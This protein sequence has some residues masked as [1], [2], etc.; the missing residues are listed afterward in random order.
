M[1]HANGNMFLSDMIHNDT[2]RSVFAPKPAVMTTAEAERWK[3]FNSY[4]N[5]DHNQKTRERLREEINNAT[6]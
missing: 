5:R 3:E 6:H 1:R 2:N 4:E